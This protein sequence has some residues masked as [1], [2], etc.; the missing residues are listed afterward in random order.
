MAI[1]DNVNIGNWNVGDINHDSN[2]DDKDID[3]LDKIIE[4]GILD[5]GVIDENEISDLKKIFQDEGVAGVNSFTAADFTNVIDAD[6]TQGISKGGVSERDALDAKVNTIVTAEDLESWLG[7]LK[8]LGLTTDNNAADGIQLAGGGA[9][10]IEEFK[11]GISFSELGAGVMTEACFNALFNHDARGFSKDGVVT[12]NELKNAQSM[13][14]SL[15]GTQW[16]NTLDEVASK[17]WQSTEFFKIDADKA[18]QELREVQKEVLKEAT[19][20]TGTS[21]NLD[22]DTKE[23]FRDI[24]YHAVYN[25]EA[26][27]YTEDTTE[28]SC[29]KEIDVDKLVSSIAGENPADRVESAPDLMTMAWTILNALNEGSSGIEGQT[30]TRD[31]FNTISRAYRNWTRNPSSDSSQV[32][33]DLISGINKNAVINEKD[34]LLLTNKGYSKLANGDYDKDSLTIYDLQIAFEDAAR[35]APLFADG[36]AVIARAEEVLGK[37]KNDLGLTSIKEIL[38]SDKL[39]SAERTFFN[40]LRSNYYDYSVS[41]SALRESNIDKFLT[42]YF[43]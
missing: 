13:M 39:S 12:L 40:E 11:N 41:L 3:L 23:G 30:L 10:N 4:E 24:L 25:L 7:T 21:L 42:N 5:D 32:M 14:Q 9:L 22:P 8:A 34:I 17:Y 15:V 43:G 26:D 20:D 16:G 28:G 33:D 37:K 36:A 6:S 29:V 27:I 38:K 31:D 35:P 19:D 18:Q 1:G 2:I